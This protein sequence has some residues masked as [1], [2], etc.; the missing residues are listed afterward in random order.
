MDLRLLAG[1][2]GLERQITALVFKSRVWFGR[3]VGRIAS[4]SY[5]GLGQTE[6]DYVAEMADDLERAC[7]ALASS[8]AAAI[9]ITNG[10]P[11]PELP[12]T[13]CEQYNMPVLS[14]RQPSS[15]AIYAIQENG[16]ALRREP[17]FME[18]WLIYWVKAFLIL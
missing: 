1:H 13:R 16:C 8:Q 15:E 11:C 14:S 17:V 4:R 6:L 10:L 5:S 2:A 7:E 12:S 3:C 9:L 18:F